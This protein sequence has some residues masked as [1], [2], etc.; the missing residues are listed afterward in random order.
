[1]RPNSTLLKCG[2]AIIHVVLPHHWGGFATWLPGAIC[3]LDG[4]N[5]SDKKTYKIRFS[6]GTQAAL[7]MG[8]RPPM[9]CNVFRTTM[10]NLL[11]F[12]ACT[13]ASLALL[14][15]FAAMAEEVEVQLASGRTFT[16][17]V[18]ARTNGEKLWLRAEGT[19]SA[20]IR[21]IRWNAIE[22]V[23]LGG[24]LISPTEF[25]QRVAALKSEFEPQ[26][27]ESSQV[28]A[29]TGYGSQ[30]E[31]ASQLLGLQSPSHLIR[32]PQDTRIRSIDIQASLANLDADVH[33]DGL[34]VR[35][36]P[37]NQRG[38]VIPANGTLTV[39]VYAFEKVAF[40]ARPQGRGSRLRKVTRRVV[41][42]TADDL[43][44]DGTAVVAIP[45]AQ[46]LARD[47][48]NFGL[49]HAEL[50][51]PG[52]GVFEASRDAVRIQPF[53]PTRDHLELK[54]QSRWLATE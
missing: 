3:L 33:A 36:I 45:F 41:S 5:L 22:S 50:V 52:Q 53:A 1:M 28:I 25:K 49:V 34:R 21:P 26:M 8:H 31:R 47:I 18:D 23:Q 38:D 15:P 35:L 29:E 14:F 2:F 30:A 7:L 42:L 11:R 9:T 27:P 24:E 12:T 10:L 44:P 39:E 37:T 20:V 51:V 46:M 17:K 32:R 48:D 40:N 6:N 43:R 13:I 19:A 4:A 54:G 16:G